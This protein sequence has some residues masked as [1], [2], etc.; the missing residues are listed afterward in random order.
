MLARTHG[1]P[2]TPTTLGKEIANFVY[3]LRRQAELFSTVAIHGKFNGAVGNYNAH[4]TAY[5]DADWIAITNRFL[6]SLG[7]TPTE[8]TT[9]IEPHDWIAE[10]CQA[11]ARLNTVLVDLCRDCWSYISLGYFRSRPVAAR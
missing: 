9:Q 10:Y 8:Y 4:V 5:P 6:E 7:V 1:Q 2:A 3:R 11:L